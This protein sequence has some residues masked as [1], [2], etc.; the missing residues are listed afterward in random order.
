MTKT[1]SRLWQLPES[2]HVIQLADDGGVIVGQ[3]DVANYERGL[4]RQSRLKLRQ[5]LIDL[6]GP[7]YVLNGRWVPN[8]TLSRR[9]A[10]IV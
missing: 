9:D 2:H 4:R 5:I 10:F 6:D 7:E 1:A 8:A 3:H